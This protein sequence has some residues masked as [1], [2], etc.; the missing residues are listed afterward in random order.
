MIH[1]LSG[2]ETSAIE[3]ALSLIEEKEAADIIK[4]VSYD[5]GFNYKNK[6]ASSTYTTGQKKEFIEI[7]KQYKEVKL[8]PEYL[9][10]RL[11]HAMGRNEQAITTQLYEAKR[12]INKMKSNDDQV[13]NINKRITI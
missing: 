10:I 2:K 11:A 5:N 3:N 6:E 4:E 9:I 12:K 13:I 8:V 1:L 7:M